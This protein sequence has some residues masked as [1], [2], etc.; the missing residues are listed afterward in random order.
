MSPRQ[1]TPARAARARCLWTSHRR[2]GLDLD[3]EIPAA[4]QVLTACAA[5]SMAHAEGHYCAH[6]RL[7][8]SAL[9]MTMI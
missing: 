8:L 6:L 5:G 1:A 4:K 2:D 7:R 9:G 3:H